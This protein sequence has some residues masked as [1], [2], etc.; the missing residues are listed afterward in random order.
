MQKIKGVDVIYS[1][2]ILLYPISRGDLLVCWTH[3]L[4]FFSEF[5]ASY[6]VSFETIP[7]IYLYNTSNL[8]ASVYLYKFWISLLAFQTFFG[9]TP[10]K[11][12]LNIRSYYL[13]EN[14]LPMLYRRL[15]VLC[16]LIEKSYANAGLTPFIIILA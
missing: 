7:C 10:F 9:L 15:F 16:Y 1:H 13:Q 3:P 14:H 8:L 6:T 5:R 4:N 2:I 11:R 12:I